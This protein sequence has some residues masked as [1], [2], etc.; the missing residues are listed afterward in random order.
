MEIVGQNNECVGC[1]WR[2]WDLKGGKSFEDFMLFFS[3]AFED[4]RVYN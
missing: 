4:L 2:L 3:R 1:T